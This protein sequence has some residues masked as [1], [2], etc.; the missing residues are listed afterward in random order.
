MFYTVTHLGN[1]PNI[2][3]TYQKVGKGDEHEPDKGGGQAGVQHAAGIVN[4]L[5]I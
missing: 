1:F 3:S 4:R 2:P 5:C